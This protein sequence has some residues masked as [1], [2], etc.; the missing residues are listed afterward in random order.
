MDRWACDVAHVSLEIAG[1]EPSGGRI[2]PN[3]GTSD[4]QRYSPGG[5][6]PLRHT[7]WAGQGRASYLSTRSYQCLE[8]TAEKPT[9]TWA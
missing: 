7:Y 4:K 5:Q 2:P 1:I 9:P 3:P 6:Q 8:T